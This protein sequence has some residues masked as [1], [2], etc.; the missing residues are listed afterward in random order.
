MKKATLIFSL[1]LTGILTGCFSSSSDDGFMDKVIDKAIEDAKAEQEAENNK[2]Y[3][4]NEN[5]A[6]T[7]TDLINAYDG[8]AIRADKE[9]K[10]KEFTVVGEIG[11]IGTDI[12]TELPVIDLKGSGFIDFMQCHFESPD[13]LEEFNVGDNVKITGK[14]VGKEMFV[15]MMECSEIVKL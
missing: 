4:L 5:N 2:E 11:E 9:F 3:K 6:I 15:E 14:C 13:G 8:N 10:D 12:V 7:S 1:L